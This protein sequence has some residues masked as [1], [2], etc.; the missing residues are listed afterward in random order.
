MRNAGKT[1]PLTAVLVLA[2][3]LVAGIIAMINSIPLS[4]RTIYG[5]SRE[6]TGIT[7]RG[8]AS[9]TAAILKEIQEKSPVELGRVMKCRTASTL[10]QSIVGKWPYY[11]LGLTVEDA[12]YYL[13]KQGMTH[14]TGRMPKNGAAEALISRKVAVNLGL[15]IGDNLLAP[16]NDD[17]F[18]PN[19]V[20][21]VGIAEGDRWLMLMNRKYLED[22]HFP[23]IDV[24]IVFA[25]ER[26]EQ[27][28]LDLWLEKNFKGR[29][30]AVLAYH[31]I[32]KDTNEMFATLYQILNAVVGTLV[33]VIT[34][35]MGMLIN[36]YQS[37]RLI[38]FGLL[39]ALGY[40]KKQILR[41]VIAESVLVVIVGWLLGLGAAYALLQFAKSVLMDPRAF[42]LDTLDPVAYLYTVPLPFAIL[43]TALGTVLWRFKNFDPIGVVERRIV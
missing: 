31:Q 9:R 14:V 3:M 8:D 12:Q 11:P 25:K 37:Q 36:I 40:T 29:P 6:F 22:Y 7:P 32:E 17:G 1:I 42:S 2:V 43:L 4:I 38:E 16:D 15:K 28:K 27:R 41:R 30:V 24:G 23:P 18:S 26:S 21:I 19:E 10:I 13:D 33:I 34:I 35:M 20:K 5:Y 39:Q